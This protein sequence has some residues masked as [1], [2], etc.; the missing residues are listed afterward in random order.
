[1]ANQP[2]TEHIYRRAARITALNLRT[3]HGADLEA[4]DVLPTGVI[5]QVE[6]DDYARDV[7]L[8]MP[9]NNI[10]YVG[11]DE[12]VTVLAT[13]DRDTLDAISIGVHIARAD[14]RLLRTPTEPAPPPQMAATPANPARPDT[15]PLA[16]PNQPTGAHPGKHNPGPL[17][18][19][20]PNVE[21]YTDTCPIHGETTFARHRAG[22][23]RTGKQR[24]NRRCLAC[25]TNY[26]LTHRHA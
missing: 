13:V 15:P 20:Q 25:H 7:R 9:G 8:E 14:L 19:Y 21:H 1:M 6:R 18:Q 17:G 4:G 22:N 5:L 12:P 23:S 16:H 2:A 3:T 10:H 11:Y 26:N 24:Y